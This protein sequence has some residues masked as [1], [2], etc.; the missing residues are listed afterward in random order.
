MHIMP[1]SWPQLYLHFKLAG[2]EDI[3]LHPCLEKERTN[4]FDHLLALPMRTYCNKNLRKAGSL[5]EKQ[6]WETAAS[7]ASLY[8]RR[9]VV[10][11]KQTD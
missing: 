11:G 10:S 9:L 4:L 6:Y 1:W 5:E 7:T 3:R 8:A 2:F